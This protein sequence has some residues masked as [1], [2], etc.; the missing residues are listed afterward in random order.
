MKIEL[1]TRIID[2]NNNE[3][4]ENDTVMI[5]TKEMTEPAPAIVINIQTTIF[6]IRFMDAIYGNQPRILRTSEIIYLIKSK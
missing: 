3:V 1:V 5:Q 4:K 2:D 6:T